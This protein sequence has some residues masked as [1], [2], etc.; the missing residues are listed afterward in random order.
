MK[1]TQ[2]MD[3]LLG[4]FERESIISLRKVSQ[5]FDATGDPFDEEFRKCF[6]EMSSL[7]FVNQCFHCY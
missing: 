7:R 3:R 1:W 5:C 4:L 6:L 2:E